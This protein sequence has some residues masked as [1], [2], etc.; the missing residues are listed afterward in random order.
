MGY[1]VSDEEGISE[2]CS[3]TVTEEVKE[4]K[5]QENCDNKQEGNR[6]YSKDMLYSSFPVH[7]IVLCLHSQFFQKM[8]T[9]SGMKESNDK[10]FVLKVPDG[11]GKYLELLIASF[12]DQSVLET[13]KE[14][15]DVLKV[16]DMAER[17]CCLSFIEEGLLVLSKIKY[18]GI[19]CCNM[20]LN[21]NSH[22]K[23][24]LYPIS[25]EE[26]KD[27][28][29]V[30]K[31]CLMFL[32]E[33]VTP[34]ECHWEQ[35]INLSYDSLLLILR[36]GSEI[37][38]SEDTVISFA[39]DWLLEKDHTP[40]MVKGIVECFRYPYVSKSF[41]CERLSVNDQIFSK[42]SGYAEWLLNA[43]SYHVFSPD[44]RRER[45]YM[46][47]ELVFRNIVKPDVLNKYIFSLQL[48]E[49]W[50][51]FF[52]TPMVEFRHAGFTFGASVS[53]DTSKSNDDVIYEFDIELYDPSFSWYSKNMVVNETLSIMCATL[54]GNITYTKNLFEANQFPLM[55]KY[56][57][58]MKFV[59][60][61]SSLSWTYIAFTVDTEFHNICKT[62]GINLAI[63]IGST[64]E[65]L[66][67]IQVSVQR[68]NVHL[69]GQDNFS[70]ST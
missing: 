62:H 2:E 38:F 8:F 15:E 64:K 24:I 26:V 11:Y 59:F 10:M 48:I 46:E 52:T 56:F 7:S 13:L 42:W 19:E 44:V 41:L 49:E 45:G 14:V 69:R 6:Q 47:H 51:N 33:V 57:S 20:I 60:T 28:C 39:Y 29:E 16:L 9:E 12:Y 21:R 18:E 37:A 40:G 43:V 35:I 34:L 36:F 3:V 25:K 4:K 68:R 58:R 67:W 55:K 61:T 70:P 65:S 50:D 17:Y 32:A 30:E 23:S 22:F 5:Q 63:V 27:M 1:E 31:S 54:P 66:K 53:A